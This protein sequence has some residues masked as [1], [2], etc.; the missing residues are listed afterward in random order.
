MI[1]F[2][3]YQKTKSILKKFIDKSSRVTYADWAGVIPA[4]VLCK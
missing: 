2:Y 1:P 3:Q 4:G